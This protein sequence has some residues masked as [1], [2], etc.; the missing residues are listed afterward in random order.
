[1]VVVIGLFPALPSSWFPPPRSLLSTSLFLRPL[2][3]LFPSAAP[4]SALPPLSGRFGDRFIERNGE[5]FGLL[6][7]TL[8]PLLRSLLGVEGF[9]PFAALLLLSSAALPLRLLNDWDLL[10]ATKPEG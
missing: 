5:R 4:C 6:P 10:A 1:M 9:L 7:S 3:L 2:L 8:F